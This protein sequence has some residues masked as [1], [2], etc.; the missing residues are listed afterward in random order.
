[1]I[2]WYLYEIA[3]TGVMDNLFLCFCM[4]VFYFM[5]KLWLYPKIQEILFEIKK[6]IKIQLSILKKLDKVL[7][8]QSISQRYRAKKLL[9]EIE[10][11]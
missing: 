1:M 6:V 8:N 4:I 11:R 2:G 5:G 9:E 3:I 7:E 10:N